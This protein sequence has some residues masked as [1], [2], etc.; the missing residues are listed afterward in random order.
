MRL[1]SG[2]SPQF[3][4]DTTQN[5]IAD[6]LKSAFFSYF[7]YY[8][9]P[10]EVASWRNSLTRIKDVFQRT[11]L[12]DHGVILEYQLPLS[13]KRL[14]CL[15]TGKNKE[16][17]DSA[18]II[19]LKQ[20]E[21][22]E[23]AAGDNEVITW[24]GNA[25]RSVLHPSVQVGQYQ[26]Y[27]EDTHT[28]FYEGE[29]PVQLR[30]CS[31]LHNYSFSGED[32]LL[33]RKFREPLKNYP[34]FSAD[35]V[36]PLSDF[37]SDLMKK[38]EGLPIL[39]RIEESKFRAS[40]KLLDHVG[41]MIKSKHEYVLL[42]E[43]LVAYDHVFAAARK[44]FRDKRKTIL[45]IKGGPGTGKSVIAINLMASLSLEG[46][47]AHYATGSKSFTETLRKIV[48]SRASAQFKYFNSYSL[49]QPNELDVLIMD[50][51]HRIRKSSVNRFTPRA[52]RSGLPQID[53]LLE[54]AKVCVFLIDDKQV[55]RPDEVGSSELIKDTA[56]RKGHELKEYQ[57]ETQFRCSGS[58]AFVNWVN[59]TLGIEK[60][61]NVLWEAQQSFD[62]KIYNSPIELETAIRQKV[63]E[64]HTG[65]IAAGFC[66]EW[67]D[68]NA[69]GTLPDDVII[70]DYRR[71]W[72]AK[73]DA[74]NLAPGIPKASF[75]AYDP[76]GINQVGCVYTAQG[77]EFDYI[78]VI[79]GRDLF[80]NPDKAEWEGRKE[81]SADQTV[82]RARENFVEL[83]KNTYRVLISRGLKGC[84]IYFM[85]EETKNFFMS[86]IEGNA[87]APLPPPVIDRLVHE[88]KIIQDVPSGGRFNIYLPVYTLA[89]AAGNF[90]KEQIVEP[91]GWAKVH[92]PRKL[93]KDMFIARV[94][95]R[96]ME[97]VIGDGSYCVFQ[98]ERG[99]SRNGKIVLVQSEQ[100]SDP[101]S[102]GRYTVKY[103]HSDKEIFPDGTW[104]H[105]KIVLSPANKKFD[106]I[107]IEK[108]EADQFRVIAE[109][110]C[111][112]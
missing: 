30:A 100:I 37:L 31:Y 110:V 103:Y 11:K 112:L 26:M 87:L 38:G 29:N 57:L 43:Q 4:E 45:L 101:E 53:E 94:K 8:P 34:L 68:P 19:E 23:L 66:W 69:D 5:Q 51:S 97:P 82:K 71:P 52:R 77:F 25:K 42:D 58:G 63:A 21:K 15:I 7:R 84:Y 12:V 76:N 39:K 22:C 70:G 28:A 80:Y 109:F 108:V 10:Q 86:R 20:W 48:G 98:R 46:F 1:Y 36:D 99:G 27:L 49:A 90:S 104:Q 3:I 75:W 13:S 102:S 105:R 18:V 40:K 78:G 17:L 88:L 74:R 35:D 59:N 64:G 14:D 93:N 67:S 61:P 54:A 72:D 55:V 41:A 16:G 62:F 9:S 2:S 65:R 60:T 106:E 44:G 107:T 83:V 24:V 92:I 95:G 6:K 89:A 56:K 96:S 81:Y 50:E 73:H 91:L 111:C 85:D 79:F 47:N 32:L 33:S